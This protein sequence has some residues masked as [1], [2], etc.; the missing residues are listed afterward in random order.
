MTEN[1]YRKLAIIETLNKLSEADLL[2]IYTM[3]MQSANKNNIQ[4]KGKK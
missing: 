4:R 2:L 3:C 1:E